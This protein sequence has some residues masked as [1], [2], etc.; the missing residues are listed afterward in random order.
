MRIAVTLERSRLEC[1]NEKV[2]LR[3]QVT[4]LEKS[5]Y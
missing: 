5:F 3:A 4:E 1:Q 2:G